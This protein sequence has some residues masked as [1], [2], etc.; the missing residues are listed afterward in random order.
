MRRQSVLFLVCLPLFVACNTPP[1]P[2][3]IALSPSEPLTTDDLEVV[4][5]SESADPNSKDTV[6]Y[7]TFWFVD[8]VSRPEFEGMS[9]AAAETAKGEV[10][11]VIVTPT[12]G[13]LEGPPVASE[14]VVLN[15]PP[16]VDVTVDLE[17]PLSTEDVVA[18]ATATDADG[19]EVEFTYSW[20]VDGDE[21]RKV[22]GATLSAN[23]TVKGEIWTVTAVAKDDEA[24]SEPATASASIDNVVP[25]IDSLE[26]TPAEVYEATTLTATVGATDADSDS[27]V[28]S[29]AWWVDGAEVLVSDANTLTGEHFNKHSAILVIVTPND[30]FADGDSVTSDTLTI[31]NTVPTLTG[32]SLDLAEI[33]EADTVTCLP[34]GWADDDG[35]SA[36]YS[37]TWTVDSADAGVTSETLDGAYFSSG[38]SV[39]CTVTPNDGEADGAPAT[40]GSVTVS[41]TA[42]V[43]SGVTVSPTSPREGDTLTV[44]IGTSTDDDGDTV[45]YSYEWLVNSA[46]TLVGPSF[47]SLSDLYFAKGDSIE[48]VVT[49]NDGTEDGLSVTSAAVTAVNTEPTLASVTLIP[50]P[51]ASNDSVIALPSGG[52]DADGDTVTYA[53]QWFVDGAA[54]FTSDSILDGSVYFAAGQDVH[55]MVTPYDGEGLGFPVQSNVV[56]V[57][58]PPVVTNAAISPDPAGATDTLTCT[59]DAA[60]DADGD[61]VT[62]S[63]AWTINGS[64]AAGDVT[65]TDA[66]ARDETVVCTVTPS[67]ALEAGAAVA[68]AAL[69]VT[70]AAPQVDS[71]ALSP[72][73]VYTDTVVTASVVASDADGD[74]VSLQYAWSSSAGTNLSA[75]TGSS[76]DGAGTPGFAKG[77]VV[78]LSVTPVETNDATAIGVAAT[79]DFTVLNT[80]PEAPPISV[81]PSEPAPGTDDLLCNLNGPSVDADG[82]AVTYSF[83]WDVDGTAYTGATDTTSDSTVDRDEYLAGEVWTCTVTPDDGEEAGAESEAEVTILAG[84]KS[85]AIDHSVNTSEIVVPM[86]DSLS[87]NTTFHAEMW[88]VLDNPVSVQ[89]GLFAMGQEAS[90]GCGGNSRFK[91]DSVD[92][93]GVENGLALDVGCW[94]SP[95]G[96]FSDV[97]V[98]VGGWALV[99]HSW[100]SSTSQYRTGLVKGGEIES[101]YFTGPTRNTTATDNIHLGYLPG[102]QPNNAG[103]LDGSIA[104]FRVYD[105]IPTNAELQARGDASYD[106]AGDAGLLV[107]LRFQEGSL[108]DKTGNGHDATLV[109]AVWEDRCPAEDSDSDGYGAWEDCDDGDI[110]V[111]PGA[112][113]VSADGVDADCDG[114]DCEVG[115]YLGATFAFCPY[116]SATW[117][118]SNSACRAAGY[119]GLASILDA[120]EQSH[121]VGLLNSGGGATTHRPWIGL[122]PATS[123]TWADGNAVSY[124]YW[125]SGEPNGGS[126]FC[127]HMNRD[128]DGTGTWNDV[129]C[130]DT[131]S[132]VCSMR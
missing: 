118:D 95:N 58:T 53:Y 72:S 1:G 46:S 78:T 70:N 125:A 92:S 103:S 22:D 82:D 65:L 68:S 81:S 117:T 110:S 91:L 49:P 56:T 108:T 73:G 100:D 83:A 128:A 75:E 61:T 27:V 59:H 129:P 47:D 33:R 8:G 30:G 112:A 9:V 18:T 37:Y 23:E 28:L 63:Y 107:D 111:Y 71:V 69:V 35:D 4:F 40:T 50:D 76:L 66:H 3:T 94:A 10:W 98:T 120:G 38:Q 42:P 121:V 60:T 104:V 39:A 12:D 34:E 102:Y 97:A 130:G 32:A 74:A 123:T 114:L 44:T 41:N 26:L 17:V 109:D 77:E 126:S 124:T 55:A 15:S 67:D 19:D 5:L 99:F 79:A 89:Q 122:N 85:I 93:R 21:N 20:G 127:G 115:V 16:V 2:A 43:I 52:V 88:M 84:C 36:S 119:D 45:T 54:L 87:G 90:T 57:N 113:D 6:S 106:A 64:A 132:M 14:A 31:L 105:R 96:G 86:P 13:E 11:K 62:M 48:V 131:W 25:V 24:E 80:P 116:E 51:V 7:S 101:R 29:Y